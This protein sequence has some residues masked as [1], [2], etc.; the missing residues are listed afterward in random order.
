MAESPTERGTVVNALLEWLAFRALP[1]FPCVPVG[2]R[3]VTCA[4]TGRR[5]H[6]LRFHWPLWS[7]PATL[8]AVRSIPVVAPSLL[9]PSKGRLRDNWRPRG[10]FAVCASEIRRTTQGFG[11]FSPADVRV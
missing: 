1:A 5:Q 9:D 6:Q 8:A 7:C 11:N 3:P 10:V 4:V 2:E